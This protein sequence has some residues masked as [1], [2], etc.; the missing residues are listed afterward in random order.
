LALESEG[1][2]LSGYQREI[3]PKSGASRAI[4]TRARG[5]FR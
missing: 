3:A 5:Q 4:P 1:G 2:G